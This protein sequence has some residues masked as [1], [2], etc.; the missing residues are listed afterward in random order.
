MQESPPRAWVDIDLGALRRNGVALRDLARAPLLPM[1]KA[2]AYGLGAV[3]VARALEPVDPWGFGVSAVFE[4][5][6]LRESGINRPIVVFTP[7]LED[8]LDEAEQLRLTPALSS[9]S[10]IRRW[11][12]RAPWHLAIDTGMA[13]A[14]VTWRGAGELAGVVREHPPQG[15][16]THYHSAQ[17]DDGSMQ[18]QERRFSEAVDALSLR[19]A[20]LHAEGSAGIVR[21]DPSPYS[22]VRPGIFIYGVGSGA[23]AAIQ[24]E[25][26]VHLRSRLVETRD[27]VPGD[28]VSYDA[29]FTA[30]RPMR[31]ATAAIGYA[32][33]YPRAL[34]N[35]GLAA[36]SGETVRV[37]G[38]VTMDM[39]MIDVTGIDC[40]AGDVVTFIGGDG[41]LL[42]TVE[43]VAARADMSPYELLTGLRGRAL[44]RYHES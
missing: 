34:S 17:L 42:L 14:G 18:E 4:G 44:R 43:S 32:D 8:E 6:E 35:R 22:I 25:P 2:D 7:V 39:T 27:L 40:G 36:I 3:A 24:P 19:D 20:L 10:A 13:R 29:T 26:V 23:S 11:A 28:T 16:F 12:G 9:P 33:G 1:V 30:E 31:V 15:A 38:R 21:H 37:V 5:R 41:A